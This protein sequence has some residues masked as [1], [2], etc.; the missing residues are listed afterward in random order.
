M[1]QL[2]GPAGG[3]VASECTHRQWYKLV[4][5]QVVAMK[6]VAD[7]GGG[8]QGINTAQTYKQGSPIPVAADGTRART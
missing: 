1:V 5:D 2:L 7:D 4:A 8:L 3:A 6:L